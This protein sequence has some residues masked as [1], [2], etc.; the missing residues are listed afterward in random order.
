MSR[1]KPTF[2]EKAIDEI[3]RDLDQSHLP[4][5]AVGISI[6]G[7]PVYRKGF[8]LASMELPVT[9]SPHTRMRIYSTTKHFTCLAYLLFCEEGKAGIDD[10]I[11]KYLP[12]LHPV[13][14]RVTMRQLM[15]NTGGLRDACEIRWFFSGIENAVPAGD[16]LAL[17][18]DIK[19]INF[20]PGEEYR[21]NNGGFHILSRV[22][23]KIAD[24]SLEEV[25]RRRIFEPVGMNDSLLRRVDTDFVE[26]SATMHMVTAAGG[27]QKKYLPGELLGEGGIVST[28]DDMLR[29]LKHMANPTVGEPETWKLMGASQRLNNGAETGY[30]LG[31]FRCPYRGIDTISHGGGGLGS[32][33]QMICVPEAG[34][35]VV[36]MANRHDVSAAELV[37]KVLDACFGITPEEPHAAPVHVSGL[38][39][40]AT[41]GS[42]VQ[43]YVKDGAQMALIDGGECP[44]VSA[45]EN[46]L[47]AKL[48]P[49]WNFELRWQG[50]AARPDGI[51]Y[52]FFG[53][54]DELR[55][56]SDMEAPPVESVSGD[57]AADTID[58]RFSVNV[59]RNGGHIKTAGRFGSNTFGLEAVGA[60]L[61]RFKATDATGWGGILSVSAD[62]TAASIGT[63]GLRQVPFRC[64]SR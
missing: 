9:L 37:G 3:F 4:G 55:P 57:Y 33:S 31:L 62:R 41:T 30:G 45:G 60:R 6:A 23:E 35:N 28:V 38:F 51:R 48:W 14:H 52:E 2:N 7:K 24:Q 13:T 27:F 15:S 12:E 40:S 42:V 44:M 50:N 5:V 53:R 11:G 43:L 25:F 19:D 58:V 54:S 22:V 10:P 47:R 63:W 56:V 16:L 1:L 17:Y 64:L 36:A 34:L 29:W 49:S 26:N 61:W 20:A 21:Y 39:R 32:N 18:R 59:E 8:G 46:V